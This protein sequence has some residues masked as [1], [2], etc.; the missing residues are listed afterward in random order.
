[1][2][3]FIPY[4]DAFETS[5]SNLEK[6]LER[7]VQTNVALSTEKCH[8]MMTEGIIL[9]HYISI[10]GFKVDPAKIEEFDITIVDKPGK[11]N[12]VADFLLGLTIDENFIPTEDSFLDEY[13]FAISTYSLLYADITNYL[14]AGKFPQYLS[15][16]EKRK[17]IQQSATYTWIDRNLYQIGP[18]FQ[19]SLCVREDEVFDILK[20]CHEEPCG[21]N[22]ADK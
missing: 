4:G 17:I 9:G 3:D 22:F 13:L 2:D 5:L 10:D 21:G 7:C 19:I 18:Y 11:D 20:A 6:V 1:M 8:M 16:K 12:V 15:S 14:F